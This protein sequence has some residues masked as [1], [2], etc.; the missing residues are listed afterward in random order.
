MLPTT[1]P[2]G[3]QSQANPVMTNSATRFPDVWSLVN[4]Q[5]MLQKSWFSLCAASMMTLFPMFCETFRAL[6]KD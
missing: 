4:H 6:A 1:Y 3:E 5:M 2:T